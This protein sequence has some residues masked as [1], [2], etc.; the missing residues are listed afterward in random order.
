MIALSL[1]YSLVNKEIG[2]KALE[3]VFKQLYTPYGLR[4]LSNLDIEFR[5]EYKGNL[6]ERD[7]S[8]HQGSVWSWLIG[9]IITA[10]KRYL[11]DTRLCEKMIEP[12]KNHLNDSCVLGISE[13]FDGKNPYN[14]RGAYAQAW[15]VGEVLRAYIEDVK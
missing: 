15:G 2:K 5:G 8:Y 13:I 4:S 7:M 1:P 14:P 3:T 9:P 12:F 11:N 6:Y 10:T